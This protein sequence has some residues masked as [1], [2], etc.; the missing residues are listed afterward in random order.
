MNWILRK[1][2]VV[3]MLVCLTAG[4]LVMVANAEDKQSKKSQKKQ[5]AVFKSVSKAAKPAAK[6]SLI[7]SQQTFYPAL[8][9][10]EQKFQAKLNENME[11]EF[12]ETP[13]EDVIKY[14]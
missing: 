7:L 11:I 1:K 14:F 6:Q 10:F 13:L 9:P 3:G 8:T 12:D 4:W 2:V 5:P